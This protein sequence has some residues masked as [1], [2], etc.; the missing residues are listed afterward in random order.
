M[1]RT[2][3]V[4]TL[5]RRVGETLLIGEDIEVYVAAVRGET[6]KLAIRAPQRVAIQRKEIAHPKG[7]LNR[8][9]PQPRGD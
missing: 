4:L 7:G 9:A 2:R 8:P 3:L 6:V 1:E 5:S